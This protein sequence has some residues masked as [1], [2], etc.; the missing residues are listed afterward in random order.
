MTASLFYP[1]M[2]ISRPQTGKK[3]LHNPNKTVSNNRSIGLRSPLSKNTM[4]EQLTATGQL[5]NA[6]QA[7]AGYSTVPSNQ[8]RYNGR[9]IL[10][11]QK[12]FKTPGDDLSMPAI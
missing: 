2:L 7:N 3:Y 6:R 5:Q 12:K 11:D 8:S 9:N 10:F 4:S 1:S